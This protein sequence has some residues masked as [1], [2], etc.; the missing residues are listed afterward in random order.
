MS[1]WLWLRIVTF[2]G[3]H[4]LAQL[5]IAVGLLTSSGPLSSPELSSSSSML[6]S[7]DCGCS[8]CFPLLFSETSVAGGAGAASFEDMVASSCA[9]V[10]D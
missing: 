3:L 5:R 7:P 8:A 9:V 2:D 1:F 10:G 4:I 6:K